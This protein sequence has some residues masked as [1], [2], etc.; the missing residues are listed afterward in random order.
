MHY[1]DTPESEWVYSTRKNH[2]V[3]WAECSGRKYFHAKKFPKEFVKKKCS[4]KKSLF[5]NFLIPK[6]I[7][8]PKIFLWP[9]KFCVQKLPAQ[10]KCCVYKML[11]KNSVQNDLDNCH[12]DKCCLD[13]CL[14]HLV[15]SH[16]CELRLHG[17]F[18]LPRLCR[19]QKKNVLQVGGWL[20]G[21]G[22][23]IMPRCGF[24]LQAETCQIVSLAENPIWSQVW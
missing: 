23:R 3:W 1:Q 18:Q 16:F 20:G 9:M 2:I 14:K 21:F 15:S 10:K 13:N 7:L 19:S 17:K 6:I 11:K 22:S 24:I 5:K 12:Q 4:T 8:S